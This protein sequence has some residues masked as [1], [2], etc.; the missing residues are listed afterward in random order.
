MREMREV[1]EL[2]NSWDKLRK[3]VVRMKFR[4]MVKRA[5]MKRYGSSSIIAS[6]D[7]VFQLKLETFKLL[8]N[9]S[10]DRAANL[11]RPSFDPPVPEMEAFPTRHHGQR[12]DPIKFR[13]D[14][15]RRKS[16]MKRRFLNKERLLG[17]SSSRPQ[18]APSHALSKKGKVFFVAKRPQNL[19]NEQRERE[20]KI[21]ELSVFERLTKNAHVPKGK[22]K[23]IYFSKY[24]QKQRPH[25]APSSKSSR[26]VCQ[27]EFQRVQR[28][29]HKSLFGSFSSNG[30][31][32]NNKRRGD[33]SA[34]T[35]SCNSSGFFITTPKPSISYE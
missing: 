25:T 6:E 2:F 22:K 28:R 19:K 18:T 31:G 13:R 20:K 4:R 33:S 26:L 23:K 14:I 1:N 5:L 35:T 21:K 27:T 8:T 9:Q 30:V 3:D 16:K 34:T 29:L 12:V 11:R 32:N 10:I 24:H 15:L 7:D 17:A